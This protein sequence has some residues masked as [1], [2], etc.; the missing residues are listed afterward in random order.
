[1]INIIKNRNKFAYSFLI[2]ILLVVTMLFFACKPD[3]VMAP[4]FN[5]PTGTYNS[6]QSI[7]ISCATEGA[8]I[9]YTIDGTDPSQ[10]VGTVYSTAIKIFSTTTIKAIAYKSDLGASDIA[11]ETYTFEFS[12]TLESQL[13]TV[14]NAWAVNVL[15]DYAYIAANDN[16]ILIIDISNPSTPTIEGSC[17]TPDMAW[18]VSVLGNYAYIA[19]FGIGL[20]VIDIGNPSTPTITGSYNTGSAYGVHSVGDYAYIANYINGFQIIDVSDPS[21]PIL[22]VLVIH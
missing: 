1:M 4:T 2:I 10:T 3:S 6:V 14:G 19:D 16:G 20:Q 22:R 13:N 21:T 18:G 7:I 9:R 17:N 12:A 8:E 15:G 11:S 5:L